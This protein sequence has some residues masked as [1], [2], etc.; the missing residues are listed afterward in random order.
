MEERELWVSL[1]GSEI[2]VKAEEL[3]Q[4]MAE[5]DELEEEKRAATREFSVNS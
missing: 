4:L 2:N 5:F 1:N 3:S